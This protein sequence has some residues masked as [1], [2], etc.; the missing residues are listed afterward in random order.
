MMSEET[1]VSA[2]AE[3]PASAA[4]GASTTA[5][6]TA[7]R[8]KAPT[9]A[10]ATARR[11]RQSSAAIAPASFGTAA[12]GSESRAQNPSNDDPFQSGQRIWPD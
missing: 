9:K 10:A 3:A 1:I 7:A 2:P 8:K 4:G 6:G 12:L 5:S 11:S